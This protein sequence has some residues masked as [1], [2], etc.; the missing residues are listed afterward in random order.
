MAKQLVI[1]SP[2]E[3]NHLLP[4]I[5][6]SKADT[7]HLYA[8]RQNL[9]FSTL[10]RLTLYN[11]PASPSPDPIKRPNTIRIQLNLFAGQ[12]YLEP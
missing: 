4:E 8:P 9:G 10:D 6:N 2:Y 1:T 3:A 12:L 5:R 7:I 11:V